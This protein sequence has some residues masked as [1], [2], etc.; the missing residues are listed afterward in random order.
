[1]ATMNISLPDNMKD[2]AESQSN[3]GRYS[4][5]SDYVRDLIRRDQEHRYAIV[6]ALIEGE[7][8]GDSSHSVDDIWQRVKRRHT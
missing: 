7:Q 2:W 4:N 8:S 3:S 5:T 6:E 1:M